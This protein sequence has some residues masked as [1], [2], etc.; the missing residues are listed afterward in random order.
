MSI[1]QTKAILVVISVLLTNLLLAQQ[2]VA[3]FTINGPTSGCPGMQV[4]FTD[5]SLNATSIIWDLGNGTNSVISSPQTSY[6]TSGTFTVML[7]AKNANG[8]DTLRKTITIFNGPK[9]AF[10]VPA[11]TITTGCIPLAINFKDSSIAGSSAITNW[12]WDLGDNSGTGLTKDVS[13]SYTAPGFY[14]VSLKVKDANGCAD[15]ILKTQYIKA[16]GDVK[17]DFDA[18]VPIYCKSP[19]TVSFSNNST[20]SSNLTY[21][22]DFNDGSSADV[23]KDPQ[24][25]YA[26]PTPKT[27]NVKLT[28]KDANGCS[29]SITKPV[30]LSIKTT[31]FIT[32]L[33]TTGGCLGDSVKFTS[34]SNQVPTASSWTF[35]EASSGANNTATGA[36]AA[37]LYGTAS[38]FNVMLVNSYAGGCIDTVQKTI[39]VNTLPTPNFAAPTAELSKCQSPLVTNFTNTSTNAATY[40]WDFGEPASG[41]NN[42]ST[43]AAPSH[44]YNTLGTFTVTLTATSAVGCT[45]ALTR[46]SY[47]KVTAPVVSA[48]TAPAGITG[49]CVDSTIKFTATASAVDGIVS[50][51]WNFG[52]G[53]SP[54]TVNSTTTTNTIAYAF[55]TAAPTGTY[56][57]NVSIIT[58]GGC[59]SAQK[60][61]T[62]K[63]GANFTPPTITA[64]NPSAC[65]GAPVS[66]TR[67]APVGGTSPYTYIWNFGDGSIS[68][69][70]AIPV[71]FSYKKR[72]PSGTYSAFLNT[73]SNNGC[74]MTSNSVLISLNGPLAGFS[75][76]PVDCNTNRN[77]IAFTDTSFYPGGFG[78]GAGTASNNWTFGDGNTASSNLTPSNVY[79]NVIASY[80]VKLKVTENAPGTCADSLTKTIYVVPQVPA[81]LSVDFETLCAK[82]KINFKA[83]PVLNGT[84]STYTWEVSKDNFATVEPFASNTAQTFVP[85]FNNP[86]VYKVRVTIKDVNNCISIIVYP[87]PITVYGL[88][89]NFGA[90]LLT[91][92]TP[93]NSKFTDSTQILA[94]NSNVLTQWDWYFGDTAQ[95]VSYTA[96]H[97]VTFPHRYDSAGTFNV[98]LVVT[99]DKGCKDS[100]TRTAYIKTGFGKAIFSTPDS[101][102]CLGKNIRLIDASLG[103]IQSWTWKL[104]DSTIATVQSPIP[105]VYNIDTSR[106]DTIKLIIKGVNGCVDST[107]RALTIKMPKAAYSLSDTFS[108]CPPL[109]VQFSDSSYYVQNYKWIFGD[110]AFSTQQ[111]PTYSYALP[112]IYRDSLI[113]TSPGGCADTAVRHVIHIDG[114]KG[115][116]VVTSTHFPPN[117]LGSCDSLTVNLDVINA[118]GAIEYSWD[119]GDGVISPN[120]A[121]SASSHL[122]LGGASY[123][124]KVFLTDKFGCKV[125]KYADSSYL[126]TVTSIKAF[127]D[128]DKYKLCDNGT[129]NFRD[130][131]VVI[132]TGTASYF[133]DF[134]DGQTANVPKP[135]HTYSSVG[136]YDVKLKLTSSYG[137]V[138]SVV[139]TD[140]IRAVASPKPSIAVSDTLLCTPGKFTFTGT[141]KLGTDTSAIVSVNWVFD[142]GNTD[143]TLTPPQQTFTTTGKHITAFT[144]VNS[145]GCTTTVYDTVRILPIDSLKAKFVMDRPL[146][147][148]TGTI[149]FTNQTTVFPSQGTLAYSWNFG[150]N[151]TGTG[152][153]ISHFYSDTASYQV[154]LKVKSSL[155][156][157]DS[158]T[159]QVRIAKSP[160]VIINVTDTLKCAPATFTYT[161]GSKADPFTTLTG[162]QWTF[163]NGTT[164]TQQNPAAIT[165]SA[166]GNYIEKLKV[167]DAN[168][169]ADSAT[170][171]VYVIAPPSPSIAVSDTLLCVG[172]PFTYTAAAK[173]PTDT[174]TIA[175]TS[176]SFDNGNT[177]T[178]TLTPPDQ[179]Y[180][181]PGLHIA[182]FTAT[183]KTGC[184]TVVKDT[185]RVLPPDSLVAAFTSNKLL[186]CGN[187]NIQFSNTTT[188]KPPQGTLAYSW[189]FGD[190][191]TAGNIQNISHFFADTGYYT[192]KMKVTSTLGCSDSVK[193]TIRVA[194]TPVAKIGVLPSDVLC[195][196]GS[197]TYKD[198][199]TYDPYT[200]AQG[201]NWTFANSTTSTLQNPVAVTYA[202]VGTYNEKL[203]VTD[204]NGCTATDTRNVYVVAR[205]Y[206]P[207]ILND[208]DT[209]ICMPGKINMTGTA[210]P[211]IS[212]IVSWKWELGNGATFDGQNPGNQ[213]FALGTS[214]NKLTITDVSGC[215]LAVTKTVTVKPLPAV[216]ALKDTT[217]CVGT[218]TPLTALG[219]AT[220]LWTPAA[221]LDDNTKA[222]PI[223]SPLIDT[224]YVVIGTDIYGCQN[225]DS[226]TVS[227]L[228]K[229]T[230]NV[231]KVADSLCIGQSRQLVASGAPA[232]TWSPSTALSS[233]S[234][235]NPIANPTANTQYQVTGYDALHCFDTTVNINLSVFKYPTV[236]A[237]PDIQLLVGKT[238]T[239]TPT[240][241]ADVVSYAWTPVNENINCATCATPEVTGYATTNYIL[242]VT[243]DGKCSAQDTVRVVVLCDKSVIF[244]PNTFSPNGD[245]QNDV[246]MIRGSR[247]LYSV[248]SMVIFNRYG[249]KVF[250][251]KDFAP[252]TPAYGW[253]GTVNGQKADVDAYVYMVEAICTNGEIF[254]FQGTVT[255]IR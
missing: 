148:D 102:T 68:N 225:S 179:V 95:A 2:P 150:D 154:K 42:T 152:N 199:T 249:Q 13:Y 77:A 103:T 11:G 121:A 172:L 15:S 94:G 188:T 181:T 36:T 70:A 153:A 69:N 224:K 116:I 161:D 35:G 160:K 53:T 122:Y 48:V 205:K 210:T 9:A 215:V 139:K 27:F 240:V 20:S 23:S 83:T 66:F 61:L 132:L 220:Y 173:L 107:T 90:D 191:Q 85:T 44:T 87:N 18:F 216:V 193:H 241:S 96:P 72:P 78:A 244:I 155:G 206:T 34:N 93:L 39:V 145:T 165:Y 104:H 251:R 120:Q 169:C 76:A 133:W 255:L 176:W 55:H 109:K 195:M 202:A 114:P 7:I 115:D 143:N 243:N 221:S 112:G 14:A 141:G 227:V 163:N 1:K 142:N 239:L 88:K 228:Q 22:W 32:N 127:F 233:V 212:G 24:H 151:N 52:D 123:L 49:I 21:S 238:T 189:D 234:I 158:T 54:V 41:A 138:D 213:T 180:T 129:I 92:C 156:C 230:M 105:K 86:G 134:G 74:T 147:C 207:V 58:G 200:T 100:L 157:E 177:Y 242:K 131:G 75:Y 232:Y 168:G 149:Q 45:K 82:T 128:A 97:G 19:V 73:T 231:A 198:S 223:A 67:T 125:P 209:I 192:V 194:L 108:T 37:H 117:L 219:A 46:A 113:V 5:Q 248:K 140:Y 118:N 204:A 253:D 167:T 170:R 186:I 40:K 184:T 218:S 6:N 229:Y 81:T 65:Y 26:F 47:I 250:E 106:V 29:S 164:S 30:S 4:S 196:P 182:T 89:A 178:N 8:T 236:N 226:L 237:G 222:K 235:G 187:G 43:L 57:I 175:S 126:V 111:N 33:P 124:P 99:D 245:N 119:Y 254:K 130:T 25:L 56:P 166:I 174:A 137:C 98:K 201:W 3:Q 91:G 252:N 51:V 16:T 101:L 71:S 246:F 217:I 31:D 185:V 64:P 171:A 214:T 60:T 208:K 80:S 247:G 28:A 10:G 79:P 136:S 190:N 84:I 62:F 197:F 110:G 211:D 38:S 50:Y 162:W 183:N 17:A 135:S 59:T 63:V 146:A 144:S 12:S 159:Q 203:V